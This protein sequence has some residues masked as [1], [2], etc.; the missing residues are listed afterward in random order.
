[1]SFLLSFLV[2][3]E[4]SYEAFFV[5]EPGRLGCFLEPC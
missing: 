5:G 3:L 2:L 1:M 4:S